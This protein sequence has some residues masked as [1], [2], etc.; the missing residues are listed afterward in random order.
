MQLKSSQVWYRSRTNGT[1]LLQLPPL[2]PNR[3]SHLWAANLSNLVRCS[4]SISSSDSQFLRFLLPNRQQH[5]KLLLPLRI[6]V[7][8][9]ISRCSSTVISNSTSRSFMPRQHLHKLNLRARARLLKIKIS[10]HLS[11]P[12]TKKATWALRSMSPSSR[13]R[14]NLALRTKKLRKKTPSPAQFG[15]RNSQGRQTPRKSRIL[16]KSHQ[17]VSR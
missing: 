2:T 5:Q 9:S 12:T 8:S 16:F 4:S 14:L 17:L 3:W 1:S 7:Y 15:N 6:R 10:N 11:R 13:R